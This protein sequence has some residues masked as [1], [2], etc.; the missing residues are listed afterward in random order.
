MCAIRKLVSFVENSAGLKVGMLTFDVKNAFNSASWKE[1]LSAAEAKGISPHILRVMQNYFKDRTLVPSMSGMDSTVPVTSGVPQGSV[2]GPTLW[3]IM[4]DG[5]FRES[6]PMGVE[7]LAYADDVALIAKGKDSCVLE[8]LLSEGAKTVANWMTSMGL[9]LA[10]HKSEAMVITKTRTYND[11]RLAIGGIA[12]NMVKKINYLGIIIDQRLSF[13][14]H[15][16]HVAAKAGKAAG[17]LARILPNIS[18]TKPR[19]RRL[20]AGVVHSILLYGAP[21]WSGRM[22][23]YGLSELAKCQRRIA[24]RVAS[25]YC[26]VSG[27]AAI[28]IADIPP[29][30]LLAS[31]RRALSIDRTQDVNHREAL[32][33]QWQS[34]WETSSK[35]RWTFMLI[36]NIRPWVERKFGDT[37]FHLTQAISGHGCFAS[38][39]HRF[40]KLTSPECWYCGDAVDDAQHTIFNCD[41][42]HANRRLLNGL[43]GEEMR[44]QTMVPLM[45]RSRENW[46]AVSGY[47]NDILSKKESEER[48]RQAQP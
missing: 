5:L 38:Y 6:L 35:G 13:S 40:G 42:W 41:A 30:D 23:Q 46:S 9:E 39:L 8:R 21:V 36:P 7:F 2:L 16:D 28:L 33:T 48:R 32:L 10:I 31:E 47:I 4:Y 24:L 25:A 17:N 14:A 29:I 22:S 37:N 11:L 18:A 15:A 34:R 26:T 27:D 45:L 1:I 44:P 12:I 19:K 20:L 43:L 3:N